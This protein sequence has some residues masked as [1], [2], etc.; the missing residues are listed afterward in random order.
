[1]NWELY[2]S[3]GAIAAVVAM[4]YT[5]NWIQYIDRYNPTTKWRV[6][7]FGEMN[8]LQEPVSLVRHPCSTQ[9]GRL[10]QQVEDRLE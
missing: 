4:Q 2:G 1:M 7:A 6:I 9:I 5:I 8:E 3:Q 10:K